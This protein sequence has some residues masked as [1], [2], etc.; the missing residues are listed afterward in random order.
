M[1][2]KGE[3]GMNNGSGD[4]YL[5]IHVKPHPFITRVGDDLSMEVPVT[6]REAMAGGSITLPTIDGPV[7]VKIPP[8]SQSGQTLKL[9][10]RGAVNIKSKKRGNL[11]V[12][13]VV[14]VPKTT[15]KEILKAAEKMDAFYSEDVRGK[16]KL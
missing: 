12:T 15:D 8:G 14:K 6:V 13:L 7:N 16:I 4:L 2:G 11:L 3:A 1:A 5:I 10:E 9:K